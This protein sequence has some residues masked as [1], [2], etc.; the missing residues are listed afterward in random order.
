MPMWKQ[1]LSAIIFLI[2]CMNL[3]SDRICGQN[4]ARVNK[5]KLVELIDS[6]FVAKKEKLIYRHGYSDPNLD[7]YILKDKSHLL[8]SKVLNEGYFVDFDT[9]SKSFLRFID[10]NVPLNEAIADFLHLNECINKYENSFRAFFNNEK[11][12]FLNGDS[13]LL[14]LLSERAADVRKNSALRLPLF[15]YIGEKIRSLNNW[16]WEVDFGLNIAHTVIVRKSDGEIFNPKRLVDGYFSE[17]VDDVC[18]LINFYLNVSG[19][20]K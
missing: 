9:N 12:S 6:G 19:N 15:V 16:Q 8:F 7:L 4:D 2:I 11:I 13:I 20:V 5:Q 14:K 10:I 17:G 3:I 18:F 1:N